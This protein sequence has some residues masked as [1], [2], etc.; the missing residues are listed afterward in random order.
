MDARRAE[1]AGLKVGALRK[2]AKEA[3]AA[4]ARVEEAI[5]EED[6]AAIVALIIH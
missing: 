1:L 3:G 5:D 6:K 4:M 2:V